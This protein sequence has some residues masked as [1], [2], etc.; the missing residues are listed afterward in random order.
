MLRS[1]FT[2]FLSFLKQQISFPSIFLSILSGIKLNFSVLSK[3]KH[4]ILWSK[5]QFHKCLKFFGKFKIE[6]Q[7]LCNIP[8]ASF[9]PHFYLIRIFHFEKDALSPKLFGLFCLKKG[10]LVTPWWHALTFPPNV[11][12]GPLWCRKWIFKLKL[13]LIPWLFAKLYLNS[14]C[15]QRDITWKA[16]CPKLTFIVKKCAQICVT[17]WQFKKACMKQRPVVQF[18]NH[19]LFPSILIK[20]N[21]TSIEKCLHFLQMCQNMLFLLQKIQVSR[22]DIYEIAEKQPIKVQIFEIFKCFG[23]N[24]LNSSCQFWTSQFLFKFCIFIHC[25]NT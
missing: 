7:I 13:L 17:P 19:I 8:M 25:H 9:L 18:W 14:I 4:Y 1:K 22:R 2:K 21:L 24:L 3:L 16:S 6:I 23:Q 11:E 5:Q 12:K 15:F 20:T 10:L